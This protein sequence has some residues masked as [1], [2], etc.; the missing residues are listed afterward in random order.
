MIHR[1]LANS[2]ATAA[3]ALVL[4]AGP[5]A[6]AEPRAYET[7]FAEAVTTTYDM[8]VAGTYAARDEVLL[9]RANGNQYAVP[10][11]PGSDLS[12]WR[13]NELVTVSV[14]QGMMI[15]IAPS[16]AGEPGIA[17]EVLNGTGELEGIP[18]DVLV[19]EVTLVTRVT[20]VN[21][22]TGAVTFEAAAG[23]T[24]TAVLADPSLLSGI[25]PGGRDLLE[26]TYF[27]AIDIE[28]R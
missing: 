23:G 10:V 9:K 19:R 16:D 21:R 24:R 20:E 25:A 6:A 17:Y 3:L 15:A 11:A 2:A 1:Q 13:E 22:D 26:L 4:P 7:V 27:D 18:S 28:K 14:T 12:I 8:Q 5:A